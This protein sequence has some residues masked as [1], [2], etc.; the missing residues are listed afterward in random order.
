MVSTAVSFISLVRELRSEVKIGNMLCMSLLA[1]ALLILFLMTNE[2]WLFAF[3]AAG[4]HASLTNAL[5]GR[6]ARVS[7]LIHFVAAF[8]VFIFCEIWKIAR[9]S[10]ALRRWRAELKKAEDF[11]SD[12]KGKRILILYANVGS[13]H[14]SAAN[15]VEDA[16]KLRDAE[17]ETKKMDL[18][19]V[20]SPAFRFAAQTMFQK[21][22]QSLAGQHTL[23]FLYDVGD[24]GNEKGGFQRIME[25]TAG[26]G[27]VKEITKFRPDTIVCTHFLPAQLVA[28]IKKASKVIGDRVRLG[29]VI[30]DLDLQS[31][32]VQPG[33]ID[34]YFLPR[35]DSAIVLSDYEEQARSKKMKKSKL[36]TLSKLVVSGIPI[37]PRF[38]KAAE[39]KGDMSF[40]RDARDL[41][42]VK[43]GDERPVV[44]IMSGG[45]LI[46]QVYR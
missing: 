11:P 41:F 12:T 19:D 23:G 36:N 8:G 21:M 29:L 16:I 18:F 32:W 46:E 4:V 2:R 37:S 22:T 43:Q 26:T 9:A 14:K 25:D 39:M 15:A 10:I 5:P 7:A 44:V 17:V 24:H 31:M 33:A 27:L 38:T 30:T 34:V 13:G 40:M 45:K 35:S 28:T 42:N 6:T 20:A 1:P 3:M